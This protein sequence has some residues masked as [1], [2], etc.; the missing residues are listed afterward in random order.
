MQRMIL[1]LITLLMMVSFTYADEIDA[2]PA[3]VGYRDSDRAIVF[4]EGTQEQI[5]FQLPEGASLQP[6]SLQWLSDSEIAFRT[7]PDVSTLFVVDL[8][9]NV[10]E[11]SLNSP[12]FDLP[13]DFS[14]DGQ[15]VYYP[16][17]LGADYFALNSRYLPIIAQD[18]SSGDETIIGG[19]LH[20]DGCGGGVDNPM[21]AVYYQ[22]TGWGG[23]LVHFQ[24]TDDGFLYTIACTG[25]GITLSPIQ[26][27]VDAPFT[28]T[29]DALERVAVSVDGKYIAGLWM[30]MPF[31]IDISERSAYFLNTQTA[32][33]DQFGWSPDGSLY[34]STRIPAGDLLETYSPA[35]VDRILEVFTADNPLATLED[36]KNRVPAYDVTVY[37]Y[38][39][40]SQ[41][42]VELMKIEDAFAIGRL[43]PLGD[44]MVASVI[45]SGTAWLDAI[46]SGDAEG[47]ASE[48]GYT[49][50]RFEVLGDAD[51]TNLPEG[52]LH[53]IPRPVNN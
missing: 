19:M 49:P 27:N 22:E 20:G 30:Q 33:I 45:P 32:H 24:K 40:A 31:V 17:E 36:V 50:I 26:A 38:D 41:Q 8:D 14:D 43:F 35:D 4:F 23:N 21:R 46:L 13:Y 52:I 11:T 10:S 2:M 28:F 34:Y 29:F 12:T 51:G 7:Y 16:T 6:N 44:A 25:Q 9:G 47:N 15:T 18:M 48:D 53:L 37:R 42:E 1:L 5:L 3:S 39:L